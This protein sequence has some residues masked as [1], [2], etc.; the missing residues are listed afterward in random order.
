MVPLLAVAINANFYILSWL[1]ITKSGIY[2]MK[3][4]HR[5]GE[6]LI[7]AAMGMNLRNIMPGETHQ[8]RQVVYC[9]IPF[10][11]KRP[12]QTNPETERL[13]VIR[14]RGRRNGSTCFMSGG[15]SLGALRTFWNETEQVVP[16]HVQVLNA[17]ERHPF[18]MVNFKTSGGF[19]LKT[20]QKTT[21]HS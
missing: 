21:L 2:M 7:C 19:P 16:Q 15:P 6:V 13:G 5:K 20:K 14:S 9:A 12:E 3:L 8:T 18:K 11:R 1:C 10:T 17:T 4:S